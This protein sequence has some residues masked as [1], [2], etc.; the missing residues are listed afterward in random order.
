MERSKK[1]LA[2]ATMAVFFAATAS[3]LAQAPAQSRK[4][5][6]HTIHDA[7]GD[8][9]CDNCGLPVGS[10]QANA[11]G[12]KAKKGKHWGPGDGTGNQANGPKDGTGYG[13]QS[14]KRSGPQDG[15]GPYRQSG[16]QA[17]GQAQSNG[18][19]GGGRP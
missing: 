19:R 4:Q 10:G 11:T 18:R 3:V 5:A 6:Q 8:G 9:I 15:T 1:V 17:R 7:N 14:G 2:V 12:Q 13:S 16:G